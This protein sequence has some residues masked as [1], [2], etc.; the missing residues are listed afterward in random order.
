VSVIVKKEM[1]ASGKRPA[2]SEFTTS[3]KESAPMRRYRVLLTVICL[4]V[5]AMAARRMTFDEFTAWHTTPGK[6]EQPRNYH[7]PFDPYF[8][9]Q[10]RIGR[11]MV[12]VPATEKT[13][14]PNHAYWFMGSYADTTKEGPWN[15]T[16]SVFNER[17]YLVQITFLDHRY[18]PE[19]RW[20]NEKLLYL[21][22]W[23]GRVV[24]TQIIFDVEQ[25]KTIYQEMICDGTNAWQQW[26]EQEGLK[27]QRKP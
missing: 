25:E 19:A 20:I 2:D 11:D 22:V 12:S 6:W 18:L 4:G 13:W 14:S 3:R 27:S 15:S 1:S 24:G 5:A 21:D 26:Q 23:W 8:S 10:I 16:I 7:A 9:P 17:Q